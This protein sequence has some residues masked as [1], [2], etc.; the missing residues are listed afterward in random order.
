MQDNGKDML[1]SIGAGREYKVTMKRRYAAEEEAERSAHTHLSTMKQRISFSATRWPV[2]A[3]RVIA[4][5]KPDCR[6]I[7]LFVYLPAGG[8]GPGGVAYGIQNAMGPHAHC[9]FVEPVQA[10]ACFFPSRYDPRQTG[11]KDIGLHGK[12]EADGSG[13]ARL[14]PRQSEDDTAFGRPLYNR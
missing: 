9:L 11:V 13:Q 6:Y 8:G 2:S 12:T 3:D 5:R 14:H 1:R 7:I 10:P 4:G